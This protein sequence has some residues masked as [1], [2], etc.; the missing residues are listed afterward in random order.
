VQHAGFAH[1]ALGY[2]EAPRDG[3][4]I[5]ALVAQRDTHRADAPR[6]LW[7]ETL[8]F[9]GDEV[10]QRP[11]RGPVRTGQRQN[12]VAQPL[13]E[14]AR[15]LRD[16]LIRT[17]GLGLQVFTPRPGALGDARQRTGE[18]FALVDDVKD[19]AMPRRVTPGGLLPG[20]Q[21]LVPA[22]RRR[23]DARRHAG[24]PRPGDSN[25]SIGRRR[26]PEPAF[27]C[28]KAHRATQCECATGLARR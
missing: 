22:G 6:I 27:R 10:E 26:Q 7:L 19:I 1:E 20:A 17:V 16:R 15:V 24:L 8:Q 4:L 13:D 3:G 23:A 11:P 5:I 25:R 28:A 21:G 9:I 12:V 2:L 18:A 14:G